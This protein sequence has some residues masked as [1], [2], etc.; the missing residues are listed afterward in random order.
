MDSNTFLAVLDY[1]TLY[2]RMGV[3]IP[4]YTTLTDFASKR[5]KVN[6]IYA[7][8]NEVGIL[9]SKILNKAY[10]V[11]FG[12][13]WII[14]GLD[15]YNFYSLESSINKKT[16]TNIL[17]RWFKDKLQQRKIDKMS[18]REYLDLFFEYIK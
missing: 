5:N 15:L 18:G 17:T 11:G 8:G 16:G 2:T 13:Y 9:P 14:N 7:I 12:P 1:N 10:I 4:T 6:C 3:K